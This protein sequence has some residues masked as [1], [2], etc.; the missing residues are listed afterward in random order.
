MV[1]QKVR[2]GKVSSK[3]RH[4]V[5]GN[6]TDRG[7]VESLI[8]LKK[9]WDGL[10]KLVSL[11][12]MS[13]AN[14]NLLSDTEKKKYHDCGGRHIRTKDTEVIKRFSYRA[15]ALYSVSMSTRQTFDD[16]GS[17]VASGRQHAGQTDANVQTTPGNY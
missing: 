15:H 12:D 10:R 16:A 2:I 1:N 6:Q 14:K 9:K 7:L 4:D 13:Q 17:R 3:R 8:H 5:Q 11:G